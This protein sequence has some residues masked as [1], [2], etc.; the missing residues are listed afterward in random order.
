[1]P[2]QAKLIEDSISTASV[3]LSTFQITLPKALLAELN[4]HRVLSKNASSSRAIPTSKFNQLESWT[5]IRWGKNQSG[6]QASSENLTGED[7]KLAEQIW[8]DCID[9]CKEAS[10]KLSALGLHKQWANRMNDWHVL[11]DDIVTATEWDNFFNLRIHPAAQ[12]EM[13]YLAKEMKHL[14]QNN[15]PKELFFGDWHLPYVTEEERKTLSLKNQLVV[16]TARCCRVSYNNHGGTLST[17]EQDYNT[18]EKLGLHQN[19]EPKHFSPAEHQA[20]PDNISSY[21]IVEFS[22]PLLHGNFVGW[23]Q[24]RKLIEYGYL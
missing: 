18:Y 1:M 22:N 15:L 10:S 13:D 2:I 20:T 14:L 9:Y 5:P 21:G 19:V 17:L 24:H 6:M 8:K 12:P 11:V 16:S 4:T 23:N 7:L 3:R